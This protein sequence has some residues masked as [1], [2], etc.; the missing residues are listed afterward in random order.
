MKDN[1]IYQIESCLVSWET[2]VI[3]T[4][5]FLSRLTKILGEILKNQVKLDK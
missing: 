5:V 3:S 4:T 1:F 2:D